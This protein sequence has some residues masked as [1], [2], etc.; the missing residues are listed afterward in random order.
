[1]NELRKLAIG[2]LALVLM[3][4]LAYS[5]V[6]GCHHDDHGWDRNR[7]EYHDHDHDHDRDR[8]YDHHDHDYGR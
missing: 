1:M 8:D 5:G 7:D 3:V 2:R 6:V 4:G